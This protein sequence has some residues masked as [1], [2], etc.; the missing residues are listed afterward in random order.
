LEK[1]RY[2]YS[3]VEI[4]QYIGQKP[5]EMIFDLI[6]QD[7][8]LDH[9]LEKLLKLNKEGTLFLKGKKITTHS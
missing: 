3:I 2:S 5:E 1:Q 9:L 6:P 7:D 8:R 4:K